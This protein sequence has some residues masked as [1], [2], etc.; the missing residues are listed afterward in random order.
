ME[1]T[2]DKI[3]IKKD[4]KA[5]YKKVISD[6]VDIE[7]DLCKARDEVVEK[8]LQS[9]KQINSDEAFAFLNMI[10]TRLIK[11]KIANDL[12]DTYNLGE[13]KNQ[14]IGR[15]LDLIYNNKGT[16]MLLPPSP[17]SGVPNK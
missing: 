5:A 12:C 8:F 7:G 14:I 17:I 16:S 6:L 2:T 10:H 3:K 4:F 9:G 13:Y 1:K 15:E 11:I